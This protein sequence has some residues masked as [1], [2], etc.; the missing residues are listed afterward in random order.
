M[1]MK[2]LEESCERA[3]IPPFGQLVGEEFSFTSEHP[4]NLQVNV[5]YRCNLAC[6]HCFLDCGPMRDECMSRETME[7][8]LRAF[9]KHGF[10]VLDITGGSP[11]MNPNIEWFIDEAAK[12]G[13]VIVRSNFAILEDPNYAHMIDVYDRNNVELFVSMSCS[14]EPTVDKVRGKGSYKKICSAW[15]KL[16]ERGY[17]RDPEKVIDVLFTPAGES[18]AP[19]QAKLEPT[20][21]TNIKNIEDC[22]LTH[23]YCSTNVAVGRYGDRLER[24][25]RLDEY[26]R[27]L[28]DNFNPDATRNLMCAYQMN[29]DYDGRIYECDSYHALGADPAMP[30]T[31]GELADM[32]SIPSRRIN[33]TPVCLTC[34]AGA[35]SGCSGNTV[36]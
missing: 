27:K 30:Q 16:N 17:A 3:G 6:T 5:G 20:Y 34:A 12:I 23:L 18:L 10:R 35:G 11:E 33:F 28:Y 19:D 4:T 26:Q 1:E 13:H 32:D 25:G 24:E 36:C 21:K 2:T 7:D 31:I 8:V 15:R 22:E 14:E 9:A 29:V